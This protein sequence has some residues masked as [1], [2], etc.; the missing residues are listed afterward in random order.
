MR[1][2]PTKVLVAKLNTMLSVD[3]A[4]NATCSVAISLIGLLSLASMRAATISRNY[5][6][7]ERSWICLTITSLKKLIQLGG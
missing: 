3:V 7:R 2:R 5:S 6:W 4:F 1:M